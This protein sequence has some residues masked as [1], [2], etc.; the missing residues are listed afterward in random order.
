MAIVVWVS[1]MND[2]GKRVL[3]WI[4]TYIPGRWMAGTLHPLTYSAHHSFQ[5]QLFSHK[6]N[7]SDTSS[8]TDQVSSSPSPEVAG[9]TAEDGLKFSEAT[10]PSERMSTRRKSAAVMMAMQFDALFDDDE[11]TRGWQIR[12]YADL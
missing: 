2:L 1:V 12:I 4:H 8:T 3:S 10:R 9:P 6:P 7:M 11:G 5:R